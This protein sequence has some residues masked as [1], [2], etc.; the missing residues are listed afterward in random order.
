[1]LRWHQRIRPFLIRII[2]ILHTFLGQMCSALY[3]LRS[4]H[5]CLHPNTLWG[6]LSLSLHLSP[7]LFLSLF[8]VH[9]FFLSLIFFFFVYLCLSFFSLNILFSLYHSFSFFFFLSFKGR[10]QDIPKWKYIYL[11]IQ[12]CASMYYT[13][14]WVKHI[15][16]SWCINKT[17][18]D[19]PCDDGMCS[20]TSF[21]W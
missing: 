11:F 10:R 17:Q 5:R 18:K 3:S 2:I 14:Y 7:S 19:S 8:F 4:S 6:S 1:M 12:R 21:I 15:I 9:S 20:P 16:T 13:T